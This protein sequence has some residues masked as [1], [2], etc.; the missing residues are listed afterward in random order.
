MIPRRTA[1]M[2]IASAWPCL[3]RAAPTFPQ[4]AITLLVPFAP[5]GS[6]DLLGRAIASALSASLGMPVVVENRPGGGTT[7]AAKRLVR[8]APDGHTLLLA[9]TSTMVIH[10]LLNPS[11][12]FDVDHDFAGISMLALAPMVLVSRARS[13]FNSA[14]DLVKVAQLKPGQLNFASPG[15]GTSLH[16]AA[17]LFA[18]TAG[19]QLVH[20]PYRGSQQAL[21]AL[22]ADEVQFYFDLIPSA[23]P[24]IDAGQL[25]ALAVTHR[26]RASALPNVPTLFEQGWRDFDASARFALVAPAGTP[27][28]TVELVNQA[29]AK[30]LAD[31]SL[32]TRFANQGMELVASPPQAVLAQFAKDR[33]EWAPLVR[34][35]QI[36]IDGPT[37]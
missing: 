20:V 3:S 4:R 9:S 36:R 2:G 25:N 17:E 29:V 34:D 26:Q 30:A 15:Y 27:V 23:K 6:T 13:Q 22:L 18:A 8:A 21:Q 7:V 12:G 14:M 5:G 10:P 19:L 28:S 11:P 31:A 32:K 35:R 16:L 33:T 1:L 37:P 24:L